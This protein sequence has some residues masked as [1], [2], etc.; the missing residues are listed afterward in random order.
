[1]V[2]GVALL[3]WAQV[4]VDCL[5]VGISSIDGAAEVHQEGRALPLEAGLDVGVGEVSSVSMRVYSDCVV[6]HHS[7]ARAPVYRLR[8]I[9]SAIEAMALSGPWSLASEM[10][11]LDI[12]S[13]I[14]LRWLGMH[15]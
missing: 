12:P 9:Q 1:M 7:D 2:S 15:L 10:N 13:V 5:G 3:L 14:L 6:W 8:M 4:D 11:Q